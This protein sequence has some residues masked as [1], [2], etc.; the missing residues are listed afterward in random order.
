MR[1]GAL[2]LTAA[3]LLAQSPRPLPWEPPAALPWRAAPPEEPPEP[4]PSPE[5]APGPL[6]KVELREDGALRIVDAKGVIRVRAG[7][8]GRPVKAW[9][10]GGTPLS[11]AHG[12]WAFPAQTPLSRG[13][14]ALPIGK[15]DFR[16]GLQGLLWILD[17]GEQ[18][19]TVV[20][21]ATGRIAH[22]ALPG[23]EHLGIAFYPDRLGVQQLATS[24]ALEQARP[25]WSLSWLSLLPQML[26]LA[27]PLPAPP[28]GTALRPFPH[29]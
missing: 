26:Q 14:G 29:D 8:P 12:S 22:L 17:D 21:P 16:P 13:V 18:C 3:T 10:D 11:P 24:V 20:H 1:L 6:L 5:P 2:F 4:M 28:P 27:Q 9:R 25:C 23:G 19:L 15:G 7:L